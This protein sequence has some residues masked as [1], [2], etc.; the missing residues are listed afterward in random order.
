VSVS[1][2]PTLAEDR[3]D[4][5]SEDGGLVVPVLAEPCPRH[6]FARAACPGC[7]VD[8]AMLAGAQQP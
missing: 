2:D 5:S 6:G 7:A 8:V 4:V 1:P 3:D